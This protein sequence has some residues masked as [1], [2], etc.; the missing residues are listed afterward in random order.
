MKKEFCPGFLDLSFGGIVSSGEE[1]QEYEAALRELKEELGLDYT[2]E[3]V[4]K[5]TVF[6]FLGKTYY[7]DNI[8]KVFNYVFVLKLLSSSIESRIKFEDG[9][10]SSVEWFTSQEI[11]GKI[12]KDEN[13]TP[14]SVN[15]FNFYLD[16]PNINLNNKKV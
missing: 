7:E 8:V 12:K 9:E 2:D 15:V 1:G 6:E 11:I 14:D 4:K 13:I 16:N 3:D 5:N 10:V